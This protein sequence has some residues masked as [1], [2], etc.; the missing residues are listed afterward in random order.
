MLQGFE[1]IH[2][3]FIADVCDDA[4]QLRLDR[5]RCRLRRE[6]RQNHVQP[7]AAYLDEH[8]GEVFM[9]ARVSPF[10][11][12]LQHH[13]GCRCAFVDKHLQTRYSDARRLAEYLQ[14]GLHFR[15]GEFG[16]PLRALI[17]VLR[18]NAVAA[19]TF[20]GEPVGISEQQERARLH[21]IYF[22]LLRLFKMFHCFQRE[23]A[24]DQFTFPYR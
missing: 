22:F 3:L 16:Y 1:R 19:R 17:F 5:C 4:D 24:V 11:E 13:R 18:L 2:R 15:V 14:D 10:H 8:L 6:R 9:E 7:L 20:I 23:A 12:T 21:L